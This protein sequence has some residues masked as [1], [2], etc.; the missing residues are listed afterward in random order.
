MEAKPLATITGKKVKGVV[1]KDIICRFGMPRILNTN[2]GTQFDSSILSFLS[3]IGDQ[4]E[5]G[6]CRIPTSEQTRRSKQQDHTTWTKDPVGKAK[7][8]WA[9]EL[10]SILWAYGITSWVP[11]G[12]TPFTWCTRPMLLSSWKWILAHLGLWPSWRRVIQIV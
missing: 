8:R 6:V 2:H 1:W 9:D 7:G 5:D 4:F 11:I 10:P 3:L 12:E